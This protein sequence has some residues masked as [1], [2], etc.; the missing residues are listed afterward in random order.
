VRG[1]WGSSSTF[2]GVILFCYCKN[3]KV[4]RSVVVEDVVC[5]RFCGS[6]RQGIWTTTPS[7]NLT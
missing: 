1:C 3:S 6:R 2:E 4:M 5:I 7:V